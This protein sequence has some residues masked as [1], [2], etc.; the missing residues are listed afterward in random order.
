[1]NPH[2]S[3]QYEA[4]LENVRLRL[5]AMGGLV[6]QQLQKAVRA[7]ATQDAA[8]AAEVRAADAEINRLDVELDDECIAI[9]ALRQPAATDLRLLVCIMKAG[10]DLERVGDEA[11]RVAKAAIAE[12]ALA[13]PRS[14]HGEVARL[15]ELAATMLRR[16]LDAFARLDVDAAYDIIAADDEVDDEYDAVV[17]GAGKALAGAP[18]Q[19]LNTMWT[20]RALERIGDHAKNLCEYVVYMVKGKDVRYSGSMDAGQSQ[21][22]GGS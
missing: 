22:D 21:A 13:Q 9:I 19:L 11:D 17:Q 15:S 2:I 16:A 18:E 8:L 3:E 5:L 1:M 10:T 14:Q 12:A 4:A 20:A 6:E 7:F